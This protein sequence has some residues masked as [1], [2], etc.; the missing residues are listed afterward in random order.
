MGEHSAASFYGEPAGEFKGLQLHSIYTVFVVFSFF[1]SYSSLVEER[2]KRPGE[3][4]HQEKGFFAR[5]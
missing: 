4:L 3:K 5:I 2:T 1:F